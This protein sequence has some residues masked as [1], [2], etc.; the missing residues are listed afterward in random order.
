MSDPYTMSPA[1][2]AD[3][4]AWLME[5]VS[6][7][8]IASA[9]FGVR[10]DGGPRN[11][12]E[13][14]RFFSGEPD[15]LEKWFDRAPERAVKL[16]SEMKIELSALRARLASLVA[17]ERH[18]APWHPAFPMVLEGDALI[19]APLQ[20]IRG[21]SHGDIA[22]EFV[23][24]LP[25]PDQWRPDSLFKER[26]ELVAPRSASR[27]IAL[28]QLRTA[29]EEA[30]EW[31]VAQARDEA[32]KRDQVFEPVAVSVVIAGEGD[33]AAPCQ[34]AVVGKDP[35]SEPEWFAPPLRLAAWG[36]E[37]AVTL[38]RKLSVCRDLSAAARSVLSEF[39]SSL[40][41]HPS[42]TS[43]V[44]EPNL[45]I[46]WLAEVAREGSPRSSAE[47]RGLLTAAAWRRCLAVAGAGSLDV[48][49][50]A[51]LDRFFAG[52]AARER[53]PQELGPWTRVP[54]SAALK[55]LAA[56]VDTSIDGR[57]R[58]EILELVDALSS[59]GPGRDKRVARLREA[60]A[61]AS[62]AE[63]LDELIA[64]GVLR[65]ARGGTLEAAEPEVAAAHAARGLGSANVFAS[66]PELLADPHGSLLVDELARHGVH[67][68]DFVIA[69]ADAPPELVADVALARLRFIWCSDSQAP[70]SDLTTTWAAVLWSVAH[71]LFARE[72]H[73]L[74]DLWTRNAHGLLKEISWRFREALPLLGVDPIE[75]LRPLVP[76][77][78]IDTVARWRRTPA[79]GDPKREPQ[80]PE[81]FG[82]A[83]VEF[84]S[85]ED[86]D[87][88]VK[89]L[90]PAQIHPVHD[91]S[92]WRWRQ[93]RVPAVQRLQEVALAGDQGAFQILIGQHWLREEEELGQAFQASLG[94]RRRERP[95]T[96]QWFEIPPQTRLAWAF[97]HGPRGTVG[98]KVYQSI[99]D[100]LTNRRGRILPEPG[101]L[102]RANPLFAQLVDL[103]TELDPDEVRA[104]V[105]GALW[106]G[107]LG[108]PRWFPEELAWALAER[109]AMTDLLEEIVSWPELV[110]PK[111]HL[112]VKEYGVQVCWGD[113]EGFVPLKP[114]WSALDGPRHP[115][116]QPRFRRVT[117][118]LD[119]T[120]ARWRA[121][122]IRAAASL[123]RLGQPERLLS[124]WSAES[125]VVAPAAI[126]EQAA[127]FE[128]L[129]A[130][131]E[132]PALYV[133]REAPLAALQ[134]LAPLELDD[135]KPGHQQVVW[136]ILW[137]VLGLCHPEASQR[138][139]DPWTLPEVRTAFRGLVSLLQASPESYPADVLA[140]LSG[141]QGPRVIYLGGE[142]D[143]LIEDQS[144]RTADHLLR[145]G[146]EA[147]LR[148]WAQGLHA[149]RD[150]IRPTAM[151]LGNA[152][153]VKA[154]AEEDRSR[155]DGLWKLLHRDQDRLEPSVLQ[156][157]RQS[158][159][160]QASYRAGWKD[161]APIR[162]DCPRPFVVRH[163]M[164]NVDGATW[165]HQLNSGST[166][167]TPVLRAHHDQAP[168]RRSAAR[169][170]L[171]LANVEPEC[172]E[173]ID[174]L[175]FWLLEDPAPWSGPMDWEGP[176]E[177][178]RFVGGTT[179]L[180]RQ[181]LT[182]EEEWVAD[183]LVR[184][185]KDGLTRP[186]LG[187]DGHEQPEAADGWWYD[188]SGFEGMPLVV[189]Q[190]VDALIVRGRADVVVD[191]WPPPAALVQGSD[192]GSPRVPRDQRLRTWLRRIAPG[193]AN[194][195]LLRE[196]LA[197]WEADPDARPFPE[198]EAWELF[199]RE[200]PAIEG[201]AAS[202][203]SRL[204][205]P[206][207]AM[208]ARTAPQEL[209]GAAEARLHAGEDPRYFT[210]LL[211]AETG[212]RGAEAPRAAMAARRLL[213]DRRR[214]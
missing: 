213:M 125:V 45:V 32:L 59:T 91:W 4:K 155:L 42:W 192:G 81:L 5:H 117:L 141:L 51:L 9:V 69:T 172:H 105:S 199:N 100:S 154:W 110:V 198:A 60:V 201:V 149:Y 156:E 153:A 52:L 82:L 116:E 10:K 47:A 183:G 140:W 86:L 184:I 179:E 41:A 79:R 176:G 1:A 182:R 78:V 210:W 30:L 197:Q 150:G 73:G 206:H 49:G 50:E 143:Q 109:L 167:W 85:R 27:R 13:V 160:Y 40:E 185:W 209:V 11:T 61:A 12:T 186:W 166:R 139:H 64:G 37:Q 211:V 83:V 151:A 38:A 103:G 121:V 53:A 132:H 189:R 6:Q 194:E 28:E 180:L 33:Q 21:S 26:L 146:Q 54:R 173:L 134:A 157:L 114:V 56:A 99:I 171:M 136:R 169:W 123:A 35:P 124:L 152:E 48:F 131:L 161:D 92:F 58:S 94:E 3:W 93:L 129:L 72:P 29:V 174:A 170:A 34:V 212:E 112:E 165:L 187:Y 191:A 178:G 31:R 200:S 205:L 20:A 77:A 122:A 88:A 7:K 95:A 44:L 101:A 120:V 181:A 18:D 196:R 190:L 104:A 23:Q 164:T 126:R 208:L 84:A 96:E 70:T 119:D 130:A 128:G 76:G 8:S 138:A 203:A 97:R 55:T 62:P 16:A 75:D 133:R 90:A 175:R 71:G 43:P 158:L 15:I 137:H 162:V 19:P 2:R 204:T 106:P 127:A 67:W 177:V 159:L 17:G 102:D 135:D 144:Q 108:M 22:R 142:Q 14:F 89:I 202:L 63:L 107:H 65:E 147:P 36:P 163:A 193:H 148:F 207:F 74:T 24:R 46:A 195:A 87:N 118:E 145:A 188:S 66:H 57:A 68:A 80:A 25:S 111:L 39:S 115:R 113:E 168:D 214:E 98:W